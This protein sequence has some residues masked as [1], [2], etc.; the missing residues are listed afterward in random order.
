MIYLRTKSVLAAGL[1]ALGAT[2]AFAQT[3]SRFEGTLNVVWGDPRDGAKGGDMRYS[4]ALDDGSVV[5]LKV[6]PSA[7]GAALQ[8]FGKHV[9]IR[10]SLATDAQ[11]NRSVAAD[12]IDA[13]AGSSKRAAAETRR[14]LFI[15]LQF[16]GDSQQTHDKAFYLALTNPK[17]PNAAEHI[18]ATINGFFSRTSWGNLQWKA[19]ATDWMTLPFGKTHY[20]N[21]G[22]DT[23]CANLNALSHDAFV[24]AT[25]AGIDVSKYD[26]INFVLNN[27]LDCCAWG[28][29]TSFGGKSFGATWEPPWGQEAG[30]YSHE[31]GH[32]IGLPHSGWTY[33]AYD[34]PWDIMSKRQSSQSV[35]CAT[36][37]SAN[38]NANRNVSCTEPGDGYIAGHKD[39]LGWM[40]AENQ[41]VIDGPMTKKITLEANALPLKSGIKMIK[42][43]LSG[44]SCSGGSAHYLTVEA[45]I[46]TKLYEKG[47]TGDGVIIQD[48]QLNRGAIGGGCYFNSQSGFAVPIDATPGDWDG[49]N[50]DSNG[51]VWPNYA[52]GNAQWVPGRTYTNNSLHVS[53]TVN[54]KKKDKA[55]VVTVTRTQ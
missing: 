42:I 24:L 55:Y 28:G 8:A 36:Y 21:C 9:V 52:L 23:S 32:S 35:V 19:D 37:F 46:G 48:F 18:P 16:A 44:A 10:G 5:P 51:L 7:Q 53:V 26:N 6:A 45:R 3:A 1:F 38:D 43:C 13:A 17:K 25:N 14:V 29:S 30:T 22:W 33:Y 31:F 49:V 20:A 11:G 34:S 12:R 4:L 27:D 50:C 40:P 41:V 2:S 54:K 47:L 39:Y 15:L